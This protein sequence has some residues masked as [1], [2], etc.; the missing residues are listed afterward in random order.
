MMNVFMSLSEKVSIR[1]AKAPN[2]QRLLFT[3]LSGYWTLETTRDSLFFTAVGF[4]AAAKM[5]EAKPARHP[6]LQ[7]NPESHRRQIPP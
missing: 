5:T 4:T 2:L 7:I 3:G 1:G 6:S